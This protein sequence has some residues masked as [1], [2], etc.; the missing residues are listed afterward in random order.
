MRTSPIPYLKK[1]FEN[2]RQGTCFANILSR[3]KSNHL[4]C[5]ILRRV[6]RICAHRHA[7]SPSGVQIFGLMTS[8]LFLY[9]IFWGKIW[10]SNWESARWVTQPRH[11]VWIRHWLARLTP[12]ATQAISLEPSPFSTLSCSLHLVWYSNSPILFHLP[13]IW[14]A[15]MRCAEESVELTHLTPRFLQNCHQAALRWHVSHRCRTGRRKK[16]RIMH[17]LCCHAEDEQVKAEIEQ[18]APSKTS[19]WHRSPKWQL[20]C[21]HISKAQARDMKKE[22]KRQIY[23]K[24]SWFSRFMQKIELAKVW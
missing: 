19:V 8:V 5:H 15:H 21:C 12:T 6:S 24:A 16:Q 13:N 23:I 11:L 22:L 7:T 18:G 17:A 2:R 9:V 14:E 1:S 10:G 3:D 20:G 4:Q